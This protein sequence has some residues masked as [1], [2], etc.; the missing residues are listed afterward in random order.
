MVKCN[1]NIVNYLFSRDDV[2]N[3]SRQKGLVIGGCCEATIRM[4]PS[5]IFEPRHAEMMLET[6]NDVVGSIHKTG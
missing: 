5:L 1:Y 3:K 6:M 4:R 2:V